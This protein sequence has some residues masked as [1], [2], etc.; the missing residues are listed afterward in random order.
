ME[1][2]S[3]KVVLAGI[4]NSKIGKVIKVFLKGLNTIYPACWLLNSIFQLDVEWTAALSA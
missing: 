3:L 2:F 4:E 1:R